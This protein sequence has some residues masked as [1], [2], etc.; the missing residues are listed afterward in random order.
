MKRSA[1]LKWLLEIAVVICFAGIRIS[2]ASEFLVNSTLDLS[3]ISIGDGIC[4]DSD[5]DCTLR[6]A[7]EE[8]NAIVGFDRVTIGFAIPGMGVHRIASETALPALTRNNI[9][10]DG[11]TQDGSSCGDLWAGTAPMWNIV[12]EG[13]SAPFDG[14]TINGGGSIIKG[15]NVEGFRN[16]ISI[17][18]VGENS[19]ECSYLKGNMSAG[20]DIV[21]PDNTIGGTS[22]GQGNVISSN[23]LVGIRTTGSNTV[24]AGNFIGTNTTGNVVEGNNVGIHIQA[25]EGSVIGGNSIGARNLLAGNIGEWVN[26]IPCG[27]LVLHICIDI[28]ALE[29]QVLGNFIGTD[30][31]GLAALYHGVDRVS[32]DIGIR[33]SNAIIGGT[34][35]SSRNIIA[36]LHTGINP[37]GEA[38]NTVI[39]GNYIGLNVSGTAAI[40]P[41]LLDDADGIHDRGLNTLIGGTTPG[42]GNVIS[43]FPRGAAIEKNEGVGM[44]VQGNIIGSDATGTSTDASFGNKLGIIILRDGGNVIGGT[45]EAARNII[46]NTVATVLGVGI[47]LVESS[48]N[49][50]QG[51]YIGVLA[52]GVTPL[53]I[54]RYGIAI[55][56]GS[57]SAIN[58]IGGIE[59]G[60]GN[61]IANTGA[62][63]I[64]TY[65]FVSALMQ[66]PFC[67]LGTA[68]TSNS[69]LG[70][71]IY[72]TG[73]DL[74][75]DLAPCLIDHGPISGVTLNDLLDADTGPNNLQ[76]YPEVRRATGFKGRTIVSGKIQSTP[77]ETF[78]IE[79]FWSPGTISHQGK[80]FLGFK[81]VTTNRRGTR[82]F[83]AGNL[84]PLLGP[85]S[86]TATATDSQGNTSEFSVSIEARLTANAL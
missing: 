86:I 47:V 76:N 7:I 85:G 75:I 5:G 22:V 33:G 27:D 2:H 35:P 60:V 57:S 44:I 16:G 84:I 54:T 45:T 18:S 9:T 43:G 12:V 80:V 72:N 63:G 19:V 30:R 13:Y 56:G 4:M 66:E 21:S 58:I 62:A 77:N 82:S 68:G 17:A 73:G 41:A 10:I 70:N 29:T 39:Q 79:F 25:G 15:L 83:T 71:S 81:N 55:V 53:P 69:I 64:S 37:H 32:K 51:N 6:A 65:D 14:L 8:A 59:S 74:G 52:D 26:E 11:T 38:V 24:I 36:P 78:R 67:T 50:I 28:D 48:G 49:R 31:T 46:G 20:V 61:I 3:D 1:L 23:L 34:T 42:A 40:A